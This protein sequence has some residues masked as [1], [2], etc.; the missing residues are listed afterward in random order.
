M[1]KSINQQI[2]ELLGWTTVKV[3]DGEGFYYRLINPE[4]K[5]VYLSSTL[6]T[7]W[8]RGVPDFEHDL[9]AVAAVLPELFTLTVG[10]ALIGGRSA[11]IEGAGGV[12]WINFD[13]ASTNQKAA[14]LALLDYL[15]DLPANAEIH[16]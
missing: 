16:S 5:Q 7:F 6:L 12:K 1:E 13:Y 14:A 3:K 4:G 8:T 2:A 11:M 9:D 10:S 15:K